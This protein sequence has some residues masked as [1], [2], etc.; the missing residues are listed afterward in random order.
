MTQLLTGREPDVARVRELVRE[1]GDAGPVLIEIVGDAGIGKTVMLDAA[2]EVATAAGLTILR[3]NGYRSEQDHAYGVLVALLDDVLAA[4]GVGETLDP[5][6]RND[7]AG[8]LPGLRPL[9]DAPGPRDVDPLV[10]CRAVRTALR[11]VA[12]QAGVAVLID[13][14]HWVDH[15]TTCV[16]GYLARHGLGGTPALLVSTYRPRSGLDRPTPHHWLGR[17]AHLIELDRLPDTQL[18]E[19]LAGVPEHRHETLLR[20]ADGNPFFLDELV[21]HELARG[22]GVIPAQSQEPAE[23]PPPVVAAIVAELAELSPESQRLARACAVLGDP[24]DV[25]LAGEVAGLSSAEARA[26]VDDLLS[27]RLL[28]AAGAGRELRFRHPVITG[29]IYSEMGPGTRLELHARAVKHLQLQGASAVQ[30]AAHVEASAAPGDSDSLNLLIHAASEARASAPATAARL[31][32]SAVRLLPAGTAS[33][34]RAELV[35]GQADCLIRIGQFRRARRVLNQALRE[36]P[37]DERGPRGLLTGDI[38]RAERWLGLSDAM[39]LVRRTLDELPDGPSIE[40][41]YLEGVL[42]LE[43]LDHRDL[44]AM[45]RHAESITLVSQSM[46]IPHIT[47][48]VH[49]AIASAEAELG[50]P[51]RAITHI[52]L[53]AAALLRVP[54]QQVSLV[55][56]GLI[57][58]SAAEHLVGRWEDALQHAEQGLRAGSTRANQEAR[59]LL[60]LIAAGAL[61]LGGRPR[62]AGGFLEE[63]EQLAR[64]LNNPSLISL[65][66]ARKCEHEALLGDLVAV[67]A[68][69]PDS[70]LWLTQ[71]DAARFRGIAALL[72]ASA[73]LACDRPE[74][75]ATLLLENA[76]G[77]ELVDIGRTIRPVG[78]ELLTSAALA[79]DDLAGA[80]AW[81]ASAEAMARALGAQ[82]P[83]VSAPR[84]R[85][86]VDLAAGR[87]EAAMAA[88]GEAVAWAQ[89]IDA[90]YDRA[91][92]EL[93]LG[94]GLCRGG[95]ATQ[96]TLA[97]TAARDTFEAVGAQRWVAIANKQLRDL[98][99]ADGRR[100]TTSTTGVLSHRELEVAE[101]VA[102]GLSNPEI[103]A[104]LVLS[105]RTVESH[106]RRIFTKLGAQSRADVVLAVR[107][108]QFGAP[109]AG[110]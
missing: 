43:A 9:A 109:P 82:A 77:E 39:G 41:L 6:V 85:A 48:T 59:T 84:A 99:V 14:L 49:A 89:R 72:T 54:E 97:I 11:Q 87:Y 74:R 50:D 60:D 64:M 102:A 55:M 23:Y 62:E 38:V 40:R 71:A 101:L 13:D 33:Q 106:L 27:W 26:A 52:D 110:R 29:V 95:D 15:A 57:L 53:A 56:E 32:G 63:A 75:A 108:Q 68:T 20:I 88:A 76:G 83:S 42:M 92:A 96:G 78:F 73:L 47:L 16:L 25:E 7:L 100:E 86:A 104:Q 70:E 22:V 37:A 44:P 81:A 19:M 94:E 103:A 46:P 5:Y 34:R 107:S 30:V 3:A 90:P 105:K 1:V 93:L 98:G 8:L 4:P 45:R 10:V 67:R 31:Y 66:L 65:S 28:A 91:R 12:G 69:L 35:S 2:A 17:S 18:T 21:R 79:M 58:L 80:E 24:F 51:S 61:M 36:L